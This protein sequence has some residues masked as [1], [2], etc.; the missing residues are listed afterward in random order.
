MNNNLIVKDE[1]NNLDIGYFGLGGFKSK[2]MRCVSNFGYVSL[3]HQEP[4]RDV[5]GVD[6]GFGTEGISDRRD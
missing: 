6:K 2:D 1:A 3:A 4:L 5:R